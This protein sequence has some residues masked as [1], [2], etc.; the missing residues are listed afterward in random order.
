MVRSG[1]RA[2]HRPKGLTL[3][4][5]ALSIPRG[6]NGFIGIEEPIMDVIAEST[7]RILL[8]R[9]NLSGAQRFATRALIR[10]SIAQLRAERRQFH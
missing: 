6:S 1:G 5:D 8:P 9:R 7:L 3:I 4:D 10:R 2:G